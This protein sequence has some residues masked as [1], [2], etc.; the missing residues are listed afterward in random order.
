MYF[1]GGYVIQVLKPMH[2]ATKRLQKVPK[3]IKTQAPPASRHSFIAVRMG[4]SI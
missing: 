3:A 1:Q 4:F 2:T